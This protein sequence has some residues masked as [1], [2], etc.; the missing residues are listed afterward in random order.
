M[1][2][3]SPETVGSDFDGEMRKANKRALKFDAELHPALRTV[4]SFDRT[5]QQ[6][7]VNLI[8]TQ[9]HNS[10]HYL[11]KQLFFQY[12]RFSS[13]LAQV[14]TTCDKYNIGKDESSLPPPDSYEVRR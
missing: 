1:G 12:Y 3:E 4:G 14:Q 6:D 9:C 7:M 10:I 11:T 8:K 5:H 2:L 13:R